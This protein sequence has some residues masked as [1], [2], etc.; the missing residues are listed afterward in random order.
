[1]ENEIPPREPKSISE[2]AL[3]IFEV[4]INT[5]RVR[6]ENFIYQ[7]SNLNEYIRRH[8]EFDKY[9]VPSKNKDMYAALHMDFVFSTV[10][11]IEAFHGALTAAWEYSTKRN[12]NI[13]KVLSILFNPKG[14]DNHT[15]DK[16]KKK[17][18]SEETICRFNAI[19][20]LTTVDEPTRYKLREWYSLT[21][22]RF[23]TSACFSQ[24]Y[25]TMYNDI[26]NIYSHNYRFHFFEKVRPEYTP[27]YDETVVSFLQDPDEL[28][29]RMFFIG[30]Y[31]RFAMKLLIRHLGGFERSI[32]NNLRMSI[33][34]DNRLVFPKSLLYLDDEQHEAYN[35]F[36][37]AFG[38]VTDP[39][40]LSVHRGFDIDDQ[41][42]LNLQYLEVAKEAYGIQLEAEDIKGNKIQVDWYPKEEA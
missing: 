19:P 9:G 3:W 38:Y 7:E 30:A 29:G 21:F 28:V 40:I 24:L 23:E 10:R 2:K 1:M 31:Q 5:S 14:K 39:P 35:E 17:S 8:V 13:R 26:R 27:K 33:L 25:G 16:L 18:L 37:N 34:N 41:K 22:K 4:M 42:L 36:W 12:P 15:Q 20:L 32:Y 11:T 6:E